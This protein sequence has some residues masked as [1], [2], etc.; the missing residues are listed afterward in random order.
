M[1]TGKREQ[2]YK[3]ITC[4]WGEQVVY[5]GGDGVSNTLAGGVFWDGPVRLPFYDT[6]SDPGKVAIE[7]G[8]FAGDGVTYLAKRNLRVIAVEPFNWRLT[9][10]TIAANG[11]RNVLLLKGAAAD[12]EGWMV[13]AEEEVQ[14]QVVEGREAGELWEPA[15][16]SFRRANRAEQEGMECVQAVMLDKWVE[17]TETVGLIKT[18]AQGGDLK[19]LKGLRKAILR[20]RPG[21]LF[22]F[23]EKLA[24]A[25]GDTWDAYCDFFEE[26]NYALV[27]QVD[28]GYEFDW[29]GVPK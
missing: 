27:S 2:G 4:P 29:V 5:T 16:I 18:D 24:G 7:I 22:E 11:L 9:E 25:Q 1:H 14:G 17:E 12:F 19:A 20:D 26:I 15:G 3:Q 23:D 21:I 6:Y 13:P 10:K 28:K 8:A